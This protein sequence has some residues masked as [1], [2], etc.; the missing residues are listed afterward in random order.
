[1]PLATAPETIR[2]LKKAVPTAQFTPHFTRRAFLG[3][4]AGAFAGLVF[5]AGE[6]ARHEIEIIYRTLTIP[7]LPD[8][9][10]RLKI[11]Q[12][13]DIHFEEY[14]EAAFVEAIVRKVNALDPDL[15]VL[16]GDFVSSNPL[17]RRFNRRLGYHCAEILGRLQC[18]L[19]YAIL[20]NHDALVGAHAVT[21]ALDM[22][23]IPVL[24]NS[25]IPL[26]RPGGR[27]WL[28]GTRDALV[29]RP[30]LDAALPTARDVGREPLIL[31]AHEPDFADHAAGRHIDL[32]LSGHT[33]GGQVLLP[34]LPPLLL[35]EMGR[36]YVHGLFRLGDG[37][38]LYVNRGIGAVTLPFR[39]RCPPE[40]TVMT[41]QA[42]A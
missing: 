23:G 25:Y 18:P 4:A 39:F 12:I 40:I 11:V 30:D 29:Q 33:H 2:P 35:P 1:M 41:L 3:A 10:A 8:A 21:D 22:H 15:V 24:A 20:G 28:S 7:R 31:L 9:F 13:S 19:R 34:F 6:I 27:I 36:R 17:P 16:T 14:T 5:Y 26:E 37:M 32:M 42:S 38:Q